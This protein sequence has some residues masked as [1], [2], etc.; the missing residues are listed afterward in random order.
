MATEIASRLPYLLCEIANAHG[1]DFHLLDELISKFGEFDYPRKGIKFQVFKADKIALPDFEWFQVYEELFF[2]PEQWQAAIEKASGLGDV[3]IDVFD[4]YS[5]EILEK[6]RKRI[7]GLKLQASVLENFEVTE[8]LLRTKLGDMP[9]V[10]NVSGFDLNAIHRLLERFKAIS[11]HLILQIGYQSYPTAVEDTALDKVA[12]LKAAFP[13]LPL[14]FADHA[15][16]ATDFAMRV[17][18]YANLL[19]CE[20]IEKHLCLDRARAKYDSY[21]ALEP[22]QMGRLCE[23][24]KDVTKARIGEF[25]RPSEQ[26]YLEKSIQI[27]V[28]RKAVR[29]GSLLAPADFLYRRTAQQGISASDIDRLQRDRNILCKQKSAGATLTAMDFRK[30]RIGVIVAG[31]MKSTR[32]PRKAVLP[33]GGVPSVERCLEQCSAIKGVDEVILATSTLESDTPLTEHLLGGRVRL[34]RGDPDD[35]IARYLGA[36]EKFGI[37]VVVRVT[38]DCPL[39]FPEIL[40][41]LLEQHFAAGADYTAAEDAAVGTTGEIINFNALRRVAEYFGKAEY[42]EYMTW[43]FRNN[44]DHFKLNIVPLPSEYVRDYRLTLDYPEDLALFEA[45][46]S[47]LPDSRGPYL[48]RDIF[49]I[50][51]SNPD[52]PK[53]NAHLKL[54]YVTDKDLIALLNE[55]TR[56]TRKTG[57]EEV[58]AD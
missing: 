48:G 55:K 58:D 29:A 34:W 21:S 30:A 4:T 35:V 50:L 36:C 10:V 23:A 57:Q 47:Q 19:G 49:A 45:L 16:A 24:L 25:I 38:A 40:E 11:S 54:K 27:P 51:D 43:Y 1:G 28:L 52:L 31:R 32:L 42:S 17:P 37:D 22:E 6:N 39:I 15:D 7:A 3:W 12:V 9:L 2:S 33:I 44:P 13:E 14:S 26:K 8:S 53:L 20:Y 46:V 56:M 41:Y 5:V 18:A